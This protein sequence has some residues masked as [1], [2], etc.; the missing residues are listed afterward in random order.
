RA[1]WQTFVSSDAGSAQSMGAALTTG[2]GVAV[3]TMLIVTAVSVP[4]AYALS[5][6]RFRGK[7]LVEQLV[8]LPIVYPLVML[9]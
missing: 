3:A 2:L 8:A 4:A 6:Y 1:A 7:T 9:G 5:R